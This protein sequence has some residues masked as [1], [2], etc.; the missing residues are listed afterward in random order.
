M[1]LFS[2][3]LNTQPSTETLHIHDFNDTLF[4]CI[5]YICA[6]YILST[7][8]KQAPCLWAS[9]KFMTN[10]VFAVCHQPVQVKACWLSAE[11]YS[12]RMPNVEYNPQMIFQ[13]TYRCFKRPLC[14]RS[15]VEEQVSALCR[16]VRLKDLALED[17]NGSGRLERPVGPRRS[18]KTLCQTPLHTLLLLILCTVM[19][20]AQNTHKR[21]LPEPASGASGLITKGMWWVELNTAH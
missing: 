10:G 7:L 6:H 16:D 2:L 1:S 15:R 14:E 4:S 8:I 21:Y 17:C 19:D 9:L 20:T 5:I 11:N 13:A 12:Q 18:I 3:L